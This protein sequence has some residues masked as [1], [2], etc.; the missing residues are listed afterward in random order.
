VLHSEA[1][2]CCLYVVYDRFCRWRLCIKFRK[3]TPTISA[4][5]GRTAVPSTNLSACRLGFGFGFESLV[6]VVLACSVIE[7]SLFPVS[8]QS[9]FDYF[10]SCV[11]HYR[12]LLLCL[13][14]F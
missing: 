8:F 6:E 11:T 2:I 13:L 9:I 4:K 10:C 1:T 12:H 3:D 14:T 7:S 5:A